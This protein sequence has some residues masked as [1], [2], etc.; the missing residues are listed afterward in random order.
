MESQS[1]VQ[2][3]L[4]Q[5]MVLDVAN[6][7]VTLTATEGRNEGIP[8]AGSRLRATTTGYDPLKF[9]VGFQ[10]F[11]TTTVTAWFDINYFGKYVGQ[12]EVKLAVN[13]FWQTSVSAKYLDTSGIEKKGCMN[14]EAVNSGEGYSLTNSGGIVDRKITCW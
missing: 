8:P 6:S 9:E 5:D 4:Y 2:I 11:R 13:A 12:Y 1:S 10:E 7:G 3:R 14:V